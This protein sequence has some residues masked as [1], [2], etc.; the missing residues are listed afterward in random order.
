MANRHID[1]AWL[2]WSEWFEGREQCGPAET[3]ARVAAVDRDLLLLMDQGGAFR[4]KLA[5][6]FLFRHDLSQEF[7]CVGDWVCVE[8]QP[9]D[10]FGFDC[11]CT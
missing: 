1:L 5:G 3:I 9:T 10:D 11:N 7:P 4:A 2:G 8:K 6:G